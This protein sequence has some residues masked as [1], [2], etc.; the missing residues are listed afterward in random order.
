MANPPELNAAEEPEPTLQ[1]VSTQ[2]LKAIQQFTTSLTGKIEE[3]VKIDVGLL[4]HDLQYLGVRVRE[5]EDR[6][7][8]LEDTTTPVTA[9]MSKL[10]KASE[11]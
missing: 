10:E 4:R 5:V 3:D 8:L 1:Q 2:L 7:S 11:S 9:K 6:V